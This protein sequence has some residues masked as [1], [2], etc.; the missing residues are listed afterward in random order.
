MLG[1]ASVSSGLSRY[2]DFL[3]NNQMEKTFRAIMPM[4]ISGF[5]VSNK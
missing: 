3:C 4:Q 2:I 5:S 1:C